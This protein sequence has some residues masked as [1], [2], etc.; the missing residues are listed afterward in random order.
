MLKAFFCV[1]LSRKLGT[2]A[3]EW[4]THSTVDFCILIQAVG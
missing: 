3:W 2:E 4:P 1:L